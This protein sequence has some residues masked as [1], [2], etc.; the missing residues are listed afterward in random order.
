M[1]LYNLTL[2]KPSA[3]QRL[4]YGSFSKHDAEEIVVSYGNILELWELEDDNKLSVLCTTNTFSNIRSI[5]AFRP[6]GMRIPPSS[7]FIMA[8]GMLF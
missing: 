5:Q 3:I 4:V 2:Q 1:E 8:H 6:V 7:V